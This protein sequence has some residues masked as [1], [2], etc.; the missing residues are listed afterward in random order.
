MSL[1]S[2]HVVSQG[3]KATGGGVTHAPYFHTHHKTYAFAP[4]GT[5]QVF[6]P[7]GK[8][9]QVFD[10]QV[11]DF[12]EPWE[13]D[14]LLKQRDEQ[15][16]TSQWK[17]TFKNLTDP[18]PATPLQTSYRVSKDPS[19]WDSFDICFK[20]EDVEVG[21]NA[22]QLRKDIFDA[23][24]EFCK[25]AHTPNN[26][27]EKRAFT[28]QDWHG[29]NGDTNGPH[30]RIQMQRVSWDP[31]TQLR[32]IDT[33]VQKVVQGKTG[34]RMVYSKNDEV[35]MDFMSGLKPVLEKKFGL[36]SPAFRMNADGNV[37]RQSIEAKKYALERPEDAKQEA[38]KLFDQAT[39]PQSVEDFANEFGVPGLSADP[40]DSTKLKLETAEDML[41]A[42]QY[43]VAQQELNRL[44]LMKAASL[45]KQENRQLQDEKQAVLNQLHDANVNIE[46]QNKLLEAS[47]TKLAEQEKLIEKHQNVL[48]ELPG[49]A[50]ELNIELS[51]TATPEEMAV[52]VVV[53]KDKVVENSEIN[54][55]LS[56]QNTELQSNLQETSAQLETAQTA[57]VGQEETIEKQRVVLQE[58]P[59]LAAELSIE[60]SENATPEEMAVAVVAFKDKVVEISDANAQLSQQNT[61]LQTNLQETSSQ[62]ET[63][64][65]ALIETQDKLSQQTEV[66]SV[67]VETINQSAQN[68]GV[69]ISESPI[70][71]LN[72]TIASTSQELAAMKAQY[73][74]LQKSLEAMAKRLGVEVGQSAEETFANVEK[75]TQ[76]TAAQVDVLTTLNK[77]A[78]TERAQAEKERDEALAQREI[79][80]TEAH[81]AKQA[82]KVQE[83][84]LKRMKDFTDYDAAI[85]GEKIKDQNSVLSNILAVSKEQ[86]VKNLVKEAQSIISA[87]KDHRGVVEAFV[88]LGMP[89]PGASPDNDIESFTKELIEIKKKEG[90]Y[91]KPVDDIIQKV[92]QQK[93]VGQE[94]SHNQDQSTHQRKS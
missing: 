14:N 48:H 12:F 68:A 65:T 47:D 21:P 73:N 82:A 19:S 4:D 57:L 90:K 38:N 23:V 93:N 32:I 7:S 61:E 45:Y 34:S 3:N 86:N 67:L 11:K 69:E 30:L 71:T 39:S 56:Q 77:Q 40:S 63:A 17:E 46:Q 37:T 83:N 76:T 58:L 87:S 78:T 84:Q 49:L 36:P 33:P 66:F 27:G 79:F 29:L 1:T 74:D 50:A 15:K 41:I 81:Q 85:L 91:F 25:T 92:K 75:Q 5:H 64:Q 28:I 53:F 20:A 8:T 54:A 88:G 43:E 26:D 70:E 6:D 72:N 22:E 51:E 62:L 9:K 10:Q 44:K 2:V 16:N 24:V 80:E 52:A 89:I 55:Q 42:R 13:K 35:K 31:T 60:L 94:Q 59:S 18:L